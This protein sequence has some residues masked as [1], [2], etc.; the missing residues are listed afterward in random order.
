ME[1]NKFDEVIQCTCS[2]LTPNSISISKTELEFSKAKEHLSILADV[3]NSLLSRP[4]TCA[5][6]SVCLWN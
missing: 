1:L 5:Q 4:S 6:K 2:P 3:A